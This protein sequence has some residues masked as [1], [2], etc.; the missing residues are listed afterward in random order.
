VTERVRVRTLGVNA[1]GAP[2]GHRTRRGSVSQLIY[3]QIRKIEA[4]R[5]IFHPAPQASS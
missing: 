5:L 3:R 1:G 2:L 4:H